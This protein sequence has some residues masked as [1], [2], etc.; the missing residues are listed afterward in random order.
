MSSNHDSITEGRYASVDEFLRGSPL[1][2]AHQSAAR[3]DLIRFDVPL[4]RGPSN[5]DS[6][7]SGPVQSL[8]DDADIVLSGRRDQA[9]AEARGRY[10]S[11]RG[12][13]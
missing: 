1:E 3:A 7:R 8:D 11:A 2:Y 4:V 10:R 9:I 6:L 13:R 5:L 12:A